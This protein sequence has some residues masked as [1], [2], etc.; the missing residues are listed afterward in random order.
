MVVLLRN[1]A[2]AVAALTTYKTFNL[3]KKG[4]KKGEKRR[5][6]KEKK[7]RKQLPSDSMSKK[8]HED[9]FEIMNSKTTF[10]VPYEKWLMHNLYFRGNV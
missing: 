9:D 7:K 10:Q 1:T 5:K 3:Q 8:L 6:K 4:E 2:A